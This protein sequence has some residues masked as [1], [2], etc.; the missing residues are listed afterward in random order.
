M[1]EFV[2]FLLQVSVIQIVRFSAMMARVFQDIH[3]VTGSGTVL[4][5]IMKMNSTDAVS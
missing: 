4:E 5:N 3:Y 1:H 2:F